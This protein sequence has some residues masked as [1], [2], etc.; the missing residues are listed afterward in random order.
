MGQ[1]IQQGGK[2]PTYIIKLQ[3]SSKLEGIYKK[4]F[5]NSKKIKGIV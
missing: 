3:K 2:K 4:I 5:S 1:S